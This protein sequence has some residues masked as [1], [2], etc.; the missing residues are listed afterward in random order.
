MKS[1]GIGS[2]VTAVAKNART[3]HPQFWNG[4][5]KPEHELSFLSSLP[6]FEAPFRQLEKMR[7]K[8]KIGSALE[9]GSILPSVY[10][11]PS[12]YRA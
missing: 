2:I 6:S 12:N 11:T 5:V 7:A 1:H 9:G 4:K 10:T 8:A 3:G